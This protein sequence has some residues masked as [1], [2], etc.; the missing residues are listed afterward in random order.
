MKCTP[1]YQEGCGATERS[2]HWLTPVV[3]RHD[4]I[5]TNSKD[6]SMGPTLVFLSLSR[7]S[8]RGHCMCCRGS[9]HMPTQQP[10]VLK[11]HESAICTGKFTKPRF[12]SVP[13]HVN[14]SFIP[15]ESGV[16]FQ[17]VRSEGRAAKTN[18]GCCAPM[19]AHHF[20][21]PP[22]CCRCLANISSKS[23]TTSLGKTLKTAS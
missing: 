21:P 12:P 7:S 13:P 23:G 20:C 10:C 3:V 14:F 1:A 11:Q 17:I 5:T 9:W 8:P 16:D 4:G 6:N 2:G 22:P 19:R 15:T 18:F